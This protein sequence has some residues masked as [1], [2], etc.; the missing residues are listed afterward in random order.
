MLRGV[1]VTTRTCPFGEPYTEV[2]ASRIWLSKEI[3]RR[4]GVQIQLEGGCPH[5]RCKN[6]SRRSGGTYLGHIF[7]VA[8]SHIAARAT[9]RSNVRVEGGKYANANFR[10]FFFGGRVRH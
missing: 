1:E 10:A 7:G 4:S 9:T 5:F 2:C 8:L 6:E 3:F